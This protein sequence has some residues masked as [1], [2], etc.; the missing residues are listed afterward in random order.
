MISLRRIMYGLSNSVF[1]FVLFSAVGIVALM[2]VFE[3]PQVAKEALNEVEAYSRFRAAT[4]EAN[5]DN[6]FPVKDPTVR[7]IV[8]GAFSDAILR[9][10]A[11]KF[12]DS[13]YDWLESDQDNPEFS[14]DFTGAKKNLADHLGVYASQRLAAQ[15]VCSGNVDAIDPFTS[16]CKPIFYNEVQLSADIRQSIIDSKEFLPDTVLTAEDLPRNQEGT[17]IFERASIVQTIFQFA[18]QAPYYLGAIIALSAAGIIFSGPSKRRGLRSLGLGFVSVGISLMV[19]TYLFGVFLPSQT[20][21]IQGDILGDSQGVQVVIQDVAQNLTVRVQNLVVNIGF[22]L[23]I[24]GAIIL[25]G[26][27]LSRARN[28]FEKASAK[29]GLVS[30]EPDKQTQSQ[31]TD[32]TYRKAPLQSS[33]QKRKA[34]NRRLN[35]KA[36]KI[37]KELE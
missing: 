29:S 13:I 2:M 31:D 21:R 7:K 27:R 19:F 16:S 26:E 5:A 25:L 1:R 9:N 22:Q 28:P 34:S 30:S 14:L 32:T 36:R 23:A 12:I 24:V 6:G 33:E 20:E 4:I 17:T 18:R 8:D 15:P 10:N 11:E 35:K 3:T 37:A